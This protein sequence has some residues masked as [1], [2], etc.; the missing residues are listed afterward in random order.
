M[1]GAEVQALCDENAS[2]RSE[3]VR[4]A[5][6]NAALEE[7]IRLMR[8]K[9]AKSVDGIKKRDAAVVKLARANEDLALKLAEREK[10]LDLLVNLNAFPQRGSSYRGR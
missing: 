4:L 9:L 3:T 7:Q 10:R 1:T 8:G 5:S 6:K 2:L